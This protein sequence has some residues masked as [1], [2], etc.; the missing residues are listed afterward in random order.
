MTENSGLLHGLSRMLGGTGRRRVAAFAILAAVVILALNLYAPADP[1]PSQRLLAGLLI[2]LCSLPTLMWASDRQQDHSLMPYCGVLYA[3]HFAAPIFLRRDFFGHWLN[4]PRVDDALIDAA[5]LLALA[6]WVLLLAGY[7]GPIH[8]WLAR[9]LP[10]INVLPGESRRHAMVLAVILAVI[11]V[12]FFYL[13]KVAQVAFYAGKHLLPPAIDFPVVLAGHL[14]ILSILIL[15]HLQLRRELALAGKILLWGLVAYY[16][17]FGMATGMVN[18]GFKAIFALFMA[19][20]IALR[21][22]TWRLAG[23]GVLTATILIFV[24]LPTRVEF[25]TLIW[26]HGVDPGIKSSR[27]LTGEFSLREARMRAGEPIVETPDY[28][29]TF[30]DGALRYFYKDGGVCDAQQPAGLTELAFFLHLIPVDVRDL[31]D[32]RV[33]YGYDNLNFSLESD[34]AMVDGGCV[35]EVKLP[36]Y[37]IDRVRTGLFARA[38]RTSRHKPLTSFVGGRFRGIN[39]D[40]EW[41]LLT[42]DAATWEIDVGTS[43]LLVAEADESERMELA[44]VQ[45]ATTILVQA[46]ADNW[47]E[48]MVATV[49][50]QGMRVHFRLQELLDS[51]GDRSSLASGASATLY[52]QIRGRGDPASRALAVHEYNETFRSR[53]RNRWAPNVDTSLAQK[54]VLY[55]DTASEFVVSRDVFSRSERSLNSLATRLDM[56]LPLA[57]VVRQ[58]SEN[59]PYLYGETYY[60]ILFKLIPRAVFKDKPRNVKDLGQR[61]G[62]LP[63][64]NE[65]N[66]FKVHHLGEMYVN[67]GTLGVVLGMFVL[68]VLYRVLYQLFFHAGASVVT[69]AAGSHVLTVLLVD[70]ESLATAP[71]GFVVWY[72]VFLVLLNIIVRIGR[73]QWTRY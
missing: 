31:P 50:V 10:R 51:A 9:K 11:G 37:D 41:Q 68:G 26:T 48:Y 1:S 63:E 57:W 27:L 13:D 17:L 65:I 2:A 15:F 46:D 30:R 60:P 24:V 7:F 33:E 21:I 71:W 40:G 23:Y 3:L 72:A 44:G 4:G 70:M 32:Y 29:L 64:G 36:A 69:L 59:V 38:S 62:F 25:R 16:T 28:D 22:P 42:R 49:F 54:A 43:R 53:G 19:G 61:L 12:P 52:Y 45:P 47:G 73:R 8:R 55:V 14:T 66:A 35:Y 56:L 34:G 39:A 58:T 67:F 20:A 18:H 5:L 6:G